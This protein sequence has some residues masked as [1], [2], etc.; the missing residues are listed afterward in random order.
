MNLRQKGL[1]RS[2]SYTPTQLKLIDKFI[3]VL[4]LEAVSDALFVE[5]HK[6]NE[7]LM[8][9]TD[10]MNYE[11]VDGYLGLDADILT[12]ISST[13]ASVRYKIYNKMLDNIETGV[14]VDDYEEVINEIS[15]H[16]IIDTPFRHS[17][18]I[19][20]KTHGESGIL[21]IF[22][23]R[24]QTPEF[25]M[26][27]ITYRS[28]NETLGRRF[29]LSFGVL[30]MKYENR[31]F[32]IYVCD[33]HV[34]DMEQSVD[35]GVF[36]T[37]PDPEIRN[38]MIAMFKKIFLDSLLRRQNDA[39]FTQY[40]TLDLANRNKKNLK[41]HKDSIVGM[42]NVNYFTLT[43]ITKD[44]ET[45]FKGPTL[46]TTTR[47]SEIKK[48]CNLVVGHGTTIGLDN[49]VFY[50][51]TPLAE[52]NQ[53]TTKIYNE[54][55]NN[56]GTETREQDHNKLDLDLLTI[57]AENTANADRLFFRSWYYDTPLDDSTLTTLI[58][59]DLDPVIEHE[60][61][62]QRGIPSTDYADADILIDD[63][64]Q[65]NTALGMRRRK[66]KKRKSIKLIPFILGNNVPKRAVNMKKR[67]RTHKRQ[68][69]KKTKLY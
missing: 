67:G 36:L 13:P 51:A 39:P 18:P 58:S 56:N 44:P 42:P 64:L 15:S 14:E 6:S 46:I 12:A 57:V 27:D 2:K 69:P 34:P 37:S 25:I 3:R 29:A 30:C 33:K 17:V 63:L 66:S 21:D 28:F 23:S 53:E 16:Q 55:E 40:F 38:C 4:K 11:L 48:Q 8:A 1:L 9:F 43:Y 26:R 35:A 19:I 41:F 31:R 61:R 54:V 59:I 10:M 60:M 52:I 7:P 65:T 49:R 24:K 47:L 45:I 22:V 5:L 50:H 32:D 20:A 62:A 68:R